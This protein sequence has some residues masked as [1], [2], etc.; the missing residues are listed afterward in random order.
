MV[1][2]RS[3]RMYYIYD[4]TQKDWSTMMYMWLCV[5][6]TETMKAISSNRDA[7]N[8]ARSHIKRCQLAWLN[9]EVTWEWHCQSLPSAESQ[10]GDKQDS[11]SLAAWRRLIG[12]PRLSSGKVT[13]WYSSTVRDGEQCATGRATLEERWHVLTVCESVWCLGMSGCTVTWSKEATCNYALPTKRNGGEK[14]RNRCYGK[15]NDNDGNGGEYW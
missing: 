15:E 12:C 2:V 7:I 1:R 10:L 6:P 5:R 13:W 9:T 4:S 11:M 14:N 8:M 3:W